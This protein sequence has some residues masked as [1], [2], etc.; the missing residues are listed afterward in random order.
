ME[1]IKNN[2]NGKTIATFNQVSDRSIY[3]ELDDGT[4]IT[5][6]AL[7]RYVYDENEGYYDEPYLEIKVD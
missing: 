3:I 5:I 1:K 4:D 2:F 7:T 6:I